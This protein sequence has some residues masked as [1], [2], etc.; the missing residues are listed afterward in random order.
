MATEASMAWSGG[1]ASDARRRRTERYDPLCT[2]CEIDTGGVYDAG[3][4]EAL[5]PAAA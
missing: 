5:S 4:V 2:G 3:A 1:A